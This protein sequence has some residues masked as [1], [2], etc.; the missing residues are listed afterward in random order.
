MSI[1]L[2]HHPYTRAANAVWMLEEVGVPYELA[3]VDFTK[4][5]QK[6]PEHRALNTMGKLPVL[7]DDGVA[8]SES[9]AIGLY[10]ADRYAPGRLAPAL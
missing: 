5:E 2:R 6:S 7:L 4:G 1:V 3:W 9:A 8:I 10:L